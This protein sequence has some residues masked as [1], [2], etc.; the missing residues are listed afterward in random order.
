MKQPSFELLCV[1]V[2]S[3]WFWVDTNLTAREILANSQQITSLLD[4]GPMSEYKA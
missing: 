3:T 2:K 1:I 4:P